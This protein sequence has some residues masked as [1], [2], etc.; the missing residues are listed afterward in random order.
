M[1]HLAAQVTAI[2]TTHRRPRHLREALA[3]VRAE[4]CSD[5]ECLVIE[6]GDGGGAMELLGPD[7]RILRGDRLGI[8]GARNLG[9]AAARG[10]YVIFLDDDDVALPSRISTLLEA[11]RRSGADLCYGQTRRVMAGGGAAL[12]AVPTR[13]L[14]FGPAGFCDLLT[15]N[16]HVNAVL[17]RTATLREAGGF[18]AGVEHFDDWSAWLRLADRGVSMFSAGE[19]VAEWRVHE[20]G[21]SGFVSRTGAMKARLLALFDRLAPRLSVEAAAALTGAHRLVLESEITTY[22]DYVELMARFRAERHA[23]GECLGRRLPAH[24]GCGMTLPALQRATAAQ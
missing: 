2:I 8:G 17:V 13:Q 19:V 5:V 23:A 21:L 20:E 3:S 22:D 4:T 12:P 24:H 16:P 15:C 9:L 14:A 10:E 11:A 1:E 7:V 18:D 6:D